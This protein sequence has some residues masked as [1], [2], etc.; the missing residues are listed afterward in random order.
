MTLVVMAAGMGSRFGGLKQVEP[1]DKEGN[2]I[3][4]Y[5]IYDAIQAGFSKV[6]FIIKEENYELFKETVGKRIESKIKV[7]YVFQKN[8]DLP[9]GYT[10][11]KERIKPWGT[12]H[13]ILST[14]KVI[15][16]N[17]VVVN[18]DDY[19]GKEAIETIKKYCDELPQDSTNF[20]LVG[21]KAINTIS[22]NGSVKRGVIEIKEK[23]VKNLIESSIE[24][25]DDKLIATPLSSKEGSKI[26]FDTL[27]SM[28]L[29]AFT[30][31]LYDLLNDEFRRFLNDNIDDLTKQEFYISTVLCECIKKDIINVEVIST[32]ATWLGIT[33]MTD[34]EYVVNS[35]QKLKDEGVYPQELWK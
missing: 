8:D 1:I 12:G 13:A 31:R 29:F 34:K 10:C 17:F 21:Y 23:M 26:N 2:F 6:V 15:D 33:Y 32:D 28:N 22:D 11:P 5:T 19:Y 24:K 25:V 7:E 9:D 27:V 3:I 30:P 20:G 4:D 35:L 18:A 16:G 14:Q